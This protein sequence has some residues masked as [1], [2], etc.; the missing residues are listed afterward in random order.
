MGKRIGHATCGRREKFYSRKIVKVRP[1]LHVNT[2]ETGWGEAYANIC[3]DC[4]MRQN[5]VIYGASEWF[6]L[7]YRLQP[8]SV[9]SASDQT[10]AVF[11]SSVTR[12]HYY[13]YLASACLAHIFDLMWTWLKPAPKNAGMII[14]TTKYK[15]RRPMTTAASQNQCQ[16][17]QS[18]LLPLCLLYP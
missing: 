9:R 7:K 10:E 8:D 18:H 14:R 2:N 11:L 5:V 1:H 16:V 4:N 3:F 12:L 6:S 15:Y 13:A 17:K